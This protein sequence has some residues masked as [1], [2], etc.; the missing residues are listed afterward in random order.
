[1]QMVHMNNVEAM[2]FMRRSKSPVEVENIK[3][4]AAKGS[5]NVKGSVSGKIPNLLYFKIQFLWFFNKLVYDL[6]NTI[7]KS[8]E[9]CLCVLKISEFF[10]GKLLLITSNQF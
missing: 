1:M 2:K 3:Q 6:E 9:L 5:D 8:D 4:I 7:N 10:G